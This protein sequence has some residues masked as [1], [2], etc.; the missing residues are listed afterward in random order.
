MCQIAEMCPPG[1]PLPE[2]IVQLGVAHLGFAEKENIFA[3][4]VQTLVPDSPVNIEPILDELS[5][6][7]EDEAQRTIWAP[8]GGGGVE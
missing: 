7:I 6:P 8:R 5:H 4:L 1:L 2:M 3:N